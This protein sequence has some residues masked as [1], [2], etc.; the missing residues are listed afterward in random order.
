MLGSTVYDPRTPG[1][2]GRARRLLLIGLLALFVA[3][4][5]ATGGYILAR[6]LVDYAVAS[7]HGAF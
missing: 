6:D 4:L 1:P 3:A 5:L 2:S 7:A